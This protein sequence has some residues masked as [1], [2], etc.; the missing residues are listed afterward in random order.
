VNF[1]FA[2]QISVNIKSSKYAKR[3]LRFN[4]IQNPELTLNEKLQ[5]VGLNS[6]YLKNDP[7]LFEVFRKILYCKLN[8]RYRRLVDLIVPIHFVKEI[9]IIW[10]MLRGKPINGQRYE[11]KRKIKTTS[12]P[13]KTFRKTTRKFVVDTRP[14][15]S[16]DNDYASNTSKDL[17]A[18]EKENRISKTLGV[19]CKTRFTWKRS[20]IRVLREK[21][22]VVGLQLDVFKEDSILFG[23]LKYR[24]GRK[25]QV[26]EFYKYHAL[27]GL[28]NQ[29]D[30][31]GKLILF[32]RCYLV[33][34]QEKN[35]MCY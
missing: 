2:F 22:K 23:N 18:L 9:K 8:K 16:T 5:T 32:G 14:K 13:R 11:Q 34:N 27:V 33:Q 25:F 35:V 30:F 26:G 21:L 15:Q 12:K 20:P 1:Y 31:S 17:T 24:L 7:E 29:N 3:S 10:I 28:I 4:W 6:D 19:L